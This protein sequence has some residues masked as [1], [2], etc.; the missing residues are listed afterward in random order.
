LIKCPD[1]GAEV[2]RGIPFCPVCGASLSFTFRPFL[3]ALI[4]FL[5][6]CAALYFIPRPYSFFA[7]APFLLLGL[8]AFGAGSL[9]A[10][11]ALRR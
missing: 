1:C 10:Y 2:A 6:C 4:Y 3:F 9:G 5:L 8:L 11:R 7:C